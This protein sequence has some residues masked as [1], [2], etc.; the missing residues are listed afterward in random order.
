VIIQ[1]SQSDIDA[2]E[3][4][5]CDL[6]PIALALHRATDGESYA[7]HADEIKP[8]VRRLQPNGPRFPLPYAAQLWICRFDH[9][10]PVAPFEF[11]IDAAIRGPF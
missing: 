10:D 3:P 11:E 6:C 5:S 7:V 8:R 1:V 2:G 4:R 9:G